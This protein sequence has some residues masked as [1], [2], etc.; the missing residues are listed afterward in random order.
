MLSALT[1]LAFLGIFWL[2]GVIAMRTLEES[3]DRIA[4]A[5]AGRQAGGRTAV[6]LEL[7]QPR[8]PAI[9]IEQPLRAAA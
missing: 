5:L 7:S 3:G 9:R 8:I 1:T 4:A 6:V 2:I